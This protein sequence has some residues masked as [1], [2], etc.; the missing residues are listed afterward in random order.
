MT[1]PEPDLAE[2]IADAANEYAK[3]RGLPP[4]EHDVL[5]ERI[6]GV[7]KRACCEVCGCDLGYDRPLHYC[8]NCYAQK[9]GDDE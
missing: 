5:A 1:E 2:R 7:L 8:N 4:L 3:S 6:R 9:G